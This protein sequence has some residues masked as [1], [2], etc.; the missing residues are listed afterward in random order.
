MVVLLP[1]EGKEDAEMTFTKVLQTIWNLPYDNFSTE[2]NRTVKL[3]DMRGGNR[4]YLS[5]YLCTQYPDDCQLPTP[6]SSLAKSIQ[7]VFVLILGIIT[8]VVLKEKKLELKA[9]RCPGR[10]VCTICAPNCLM[11]IGKL[12]MFTY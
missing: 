2:F 3:A 9:R 10:F 6:N 7:S 12:A 11:E 8:S 4:F 5:R 1:A